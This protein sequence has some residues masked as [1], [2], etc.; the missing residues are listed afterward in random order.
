MVSSRLYLDSASAAPLHPRAR[1]VLLS[2]LDDGWADPAR[3]YTEGRQAR[4]LLD[5]AREIVAGVVGARPAEV[6]FVPSGTHAVHIGLLG[7]AAAARRRGTGV[8]ASA[9]EHSA[10]FSAASWLADDALTTQRVDRTGRLA[11]PAAFAAAAA[12]PDGGVAVAA[13]QSANHEVGTR[14]PVD[15]VLAALAEE[16]GRTGRSAVPLLVDAAQSLGREPV[17]A[18]W[19]ALT[20]SAHKWGGPAGVGVLAVRTG[21]RFVP[22]FP[23]DDRALGGVRGVEVGVA[24][25]PAVLAAAASLEAATAEA[26][27]VGARQRA[28]LDR[29]RAG[30]A[31][32]PDV[33]VLGDPTTCLPHLLTASAFG[34][35]G[36]AIVTELDRAGV[37][38]NSGSSCTA[39]T[40]TPSHV[41]LAMGVLTQG[42]VRISLGRDAQPSDADRLLEVFAATVRAVR[43]RH[44]RVTVGARRADA[45]PGEPIVLDYRGRP[46]PAPV[47]AMAEA[48]EQ[49]SAGTQVAVEADDPAAPGDIAAWSRMRG[50][51]LVGSVDL[52]DGATRTTV[53][54]ALD[55]VEPSPDSAQ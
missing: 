22:P 52:P 21:A 32:V 7:L 23:S 33:A 4:Q 53:R 25:L 15:E 1:E 11:D 24:S 41:L 12:D 6:A 49:S 39:S 13:L 43:E 46:C 45:D 26:V 40:V 3:L 18:G 35:D 36:E 44:A 19:S 14:Q 29:L 30:L 28:V 48:V 51:E 37:A 16:S 20:G 34:V 17:P 10:V 42:N 50:H 9:V 27:E 54:V 55:Q 38:V 31:E 5:V 2:A 47:I 8:V